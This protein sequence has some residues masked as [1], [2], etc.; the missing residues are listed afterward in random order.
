MHDQTMVNGICNNKH[1]TLDWKSAFGSFQAM[2]K[3][4]VAFE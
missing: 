2:S 3:I 1:A 4:D